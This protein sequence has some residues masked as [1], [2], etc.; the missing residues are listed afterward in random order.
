LN[1]D[2]TTSQ[3]EGPDH[4]QANGA[5]GQ[6]HSK[7]DRL[8]IGIC[9]VIAWSFPVLLVAIVVQIFLRASNANQAWLDDLQWW[10]YG[11]LMVAGMAYAIT[12]NSHVRV[13]VFH[14]YYSQKKK[15]R[16]E[17]IALGWMLMPYFLFMADLLF[18]YAWAS[19]LAKEG[20][21][22]PNGLHGLYYLKSALPVLFIFAALAAWP[23]YLRSVRSFTSGRF[24]SILIF[25]F[26]CYVFLLWRFMY[27]I[28]Y[29]FFRVA[30]PDV[31]PKRIGKEPVFEYLPAVAFIGVLALVIISV[32]ISFRPRRAVVQ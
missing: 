11:I 15:A 29:W 25:A 1:T 3:T 22:S 28:G 31:H 2:A 32:V 19:V 10:I 20:S 6:H 5:D 21:D 12:T 23:V 16:L 30:K 7:I 9:N 24:Y 13:D 26:P 18:H 8:V 17:A 4:A 27:Y 14:Q